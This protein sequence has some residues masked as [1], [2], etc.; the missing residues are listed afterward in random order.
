M[1]RIIINSLL[2]FLAMLLIGIVLYMSCDNNWKESDVCGSWK[3]TRLIGAYKGTKGDLPYGSNIGRSFI[4]KDNSIVDSVG[5]QRAVEE[6][7]EQRCFTM[8][9]DRWEKKIIDV[10]KR[11][12]LAQFQIKTGFILYYA[13]IETDTIFQYILYSDKNETNDYHAA[14]EFVIFSYGQDNLV[15]DLPM[16][17]YLLERFKKQEKVQNPYGLWMVEYLVSRGQKDKYGIDFFD[18]YGQCIEIAED[19]IKCC[20]GE[21]NEIDWKKDF[22]FK[23]DFEKAYGICDGLGLE[24]EE[25]EVWYGTGKDNFEIQLIP[26]ND[27][28]I[29]AS[30]EKQWFLLSRVPQYEEPS[31]GIESIFTGDW[32]I[33]QLLG[34]GYV[35][36]NL[37]I[38][39]RNDY[40]AWWYTQNVTFDYEMYDKAAVTEWNIIICTAE[41]L[42]EKFRV[43]DNI[44]CMFKDDD[45]LHIGIRSVY[46]VEEIYIV[47]NENTLIRGRNGLWYKLNLVEKIEDDE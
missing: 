30:W 1:R 7:D 18:Y 16:G 2:G 17:F 39:G 28:E 31:G 23:D 35:D 26:V 20:K 46:G 36:E 9:V 45:V 10:S 8:N 4:I 40:K 38:C 37:E 42:Y 47:I 11:E 14:S 5:L 33:N 15:I 41:E 25:L 6:A 27:D 12:N 22:V 21:E 19:Y 43:P 13:G 34:I 44:T 3:V 32:K 24:N 29:I